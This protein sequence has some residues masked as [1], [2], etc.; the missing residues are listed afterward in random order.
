MA[1]TYEIESIQ[2]NGLR[3]KSVWC[4]IRNTSPTT[5][6]RRVEI[7]MSQLS[8]DERAYI[9]TKYT[10][11]ELWD[12]G[13]SAD[14]G[15]WLQSVEKPRI[16]PIYKPILQKA[17]DALKNNDLDTARSLALQLI[18]TNE[19]LLSDF[20]KIGTNLELTGVLTTEEKRDQLVWILLL[21]VIGVLNGD[22]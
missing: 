9:D 3:T 5:N 18:G 19:A 17:F 4:V 10:G 11:R 7:V 20:Q 8:G 15:L 12:R 14:A 6:Y 2:D 16:S 21:A 1:I 22:S 13:V